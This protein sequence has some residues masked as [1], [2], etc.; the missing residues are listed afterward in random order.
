M[1]AVSLVFA[2]A[3]F[4]IKYAILYADAFALATA[5]AAGSLLMTG[6]PELRDIGEVE[7]LWI[8]R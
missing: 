1:N 4:K 8:G 7:A 2:A 6:D 3:G 5:R